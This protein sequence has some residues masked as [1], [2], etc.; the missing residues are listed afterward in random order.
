PERGQTD[1]AEAR[2][3]GDV[4][5]TPYGHDRLRR[6]IE[7]AYDAIQTASHEDH[8]GRLGGHFGA[9]RNGDADIGLL[10]CQRVVHAVAHH[11]DH[12]PLALEPT[13]QLRLLLRRELGVVLSEPERLG[14]DAARLR[15]ITG[16]EDD[17]AHVASFQRADGVPGLGTELVL[18]DQEPGQCA[19]DG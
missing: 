14:D 3:G 10:Q 8:V 12:S 6:Q 7:S 1:H 9:T 11:R 18:Q 17:V 16:E 5:G 4:D 19:V 15:V 2:P 13:Y